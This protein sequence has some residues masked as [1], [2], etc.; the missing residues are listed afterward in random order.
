MTTGA[1]FRRR[2]AA[3]PRRAALVASCLTGAAALLAPTAVGGSVLP[4]AAGHARTTGAAPG[5]VVD[6]RTTTSLS[7]TSQ[8][9]WL[10]GKNDFTLGLGIDSPLPETDLSISINVFPRIESL[11]AFETTVSS[12]PP[13]SVLYAP[14]PIPLDNLPSGSGVQQAPAAG[15]GT[16]ESVTLTL[17]VTPG[18]A[19][20]SSPS[21]PSLALDNSGD[22]VYPLQI[23]IVNSSYQVQG[24]TITTFLV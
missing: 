10:T 3:R 21:S 20:S 7:L 19:T 23:S 11:S 13:G 15:S 14:P 5:A 1:L 18:Y 17:P 22:G 16:A 6:A 4:G 9:P 24:T 12:G 2:R 8:T